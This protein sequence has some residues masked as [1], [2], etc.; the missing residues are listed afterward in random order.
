VVAAVFFATSAFPGISAGLEGY[1]L[2]HLALLRFLVASFVLAIYAVFSGIR[3]L[4]AILIAYLWLGEVPSILS[5]A[6]GAVAIL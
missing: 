5:L 3:L 6:G 2:G 1:S 4:A